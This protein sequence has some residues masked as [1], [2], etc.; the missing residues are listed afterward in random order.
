MTIAVAATFPWGLLGR[1][2]HAIP[3][4]MSL[5]GVIL[6]T[7]SRWSYKDGQHDDLGG[8]LIRLA[9]QH[10]VGTVFSGDV[11]AAEEGLLHAQRRLELAVRPDNGTVA[12]IV[13]GALREVF[14]AHQRAARK[15]ERPPIDGLCVL[16]G[17]IG[18][19][20]RGLITRLSSSDGFVPEDLTDV[21]VIGSMVACSKFQARN[22]EL[23]EQFL[24]GTGEV[25]RLDIR[26]GALRLVAELFSSVIEP[27]IDSTVGG[28][29]QI[30]T[31]THVQWVEPR[32]DRF[33]EPKPGISWEPMSVDLDRVKR[34]MRDEQ[35]PP[36][37]AL[38]S[39]IERETPPPV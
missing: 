30:V 18:E 9:P 1:A 33:K 5:G 4:A 6:V 22:A 10:S 13:S 32:V 23:E 8:K 25:Q 14:T 15:R 11:Y 36:L 35:K 34:Y 19:D 21:Q 17:A 12:S 7:D 29:V 26:E 38:G 31:I 28:S 2:L 20:G 16:V 37:A 27:G 24:G 39:S 3:G